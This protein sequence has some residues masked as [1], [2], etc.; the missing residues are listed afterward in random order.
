VGE[1]NKGKTLEGEGKKGGGRLDCHAARKNSKCDT[2][3][4]GR[5]AGPGR[6]QTVGRGKKKGGEEN[7]LTSPAEMT[8]RRRAA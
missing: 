1:E 2:A 5:A 7:L 3:K 4:Y 6:E 8:Q